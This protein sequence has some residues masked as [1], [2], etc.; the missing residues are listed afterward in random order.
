MRIHRLPPAFALLLCCVL[1][2]SAGGMGRPLPRPV[3]AARRPYLVILDW[4]DVVARK[5]V[6]FDTL[7]STFRAQ[8][9]AIHR[10]GC[11]IITLRELE[12][13]LL[14]GSPV[15]SRPVLITFDDNNEGIYR[16]AFPI[17]KQY[18]YHFTLFV[19]TA[20]VGVT[21]DKRH[22]S[23]AELKAMQ[24]S[25]LATVQSLTASHP[26]D[27]LLLSNARIAHELNVSRHSI[28]YHLGTPVY[29]FVY[30][31]DKFDDRVARDVYRAGYKM[32]FTEEW[33]NAGSSPSLYEI[34][35]YP[36][37]LR[38]AQAMSDL[39]RRDPE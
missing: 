29:A 30:P 2:V 39:E 28:E 25:G 1:P 8:L 35:R 17:L 37:I 32:A 12:A 15:P 23:W 13:H 3:S 38:F 6:W 9:A 26:E 5:T 34:H 18:G 22:N 14:Q 36:A 10:A 33:G 19:H 4:H 24:Q 31:C 16:N 27:I 20:Y 21:T 7:I 11:H